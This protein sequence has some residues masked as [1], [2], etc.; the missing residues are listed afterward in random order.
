MCFVRAPRD[1]SHAECRPFDSRSSNFRERRRAAGAVRNSTEYPR[2]RPIFFTFSDTTSTPSF[3]RRVPSSA[4]HR[5]GVVPGKSFSA[6]RV[7]RPRQSCFRAVTPRPASAGARHSNVIYRGVAIISFLL[8]SSTRRASLSERAAFLM[9]IHAGSC[10]GDAHEKSCRLLNEQI[11]DR[12]SP[13]TSRLP[14]SY[15]RGRRRP[16]KDQTARNALVLKQIYRALRSSNG[17]S[18]RAPGRL[19]AAG[20]IMHAFVPAAASPAAGNKP[21]HRPRRRAAGL[22]YYFLS[23]RR[24]RL[25][26]CSR[27]ERN[28]KRWRGDADSFH[29]TFIIA[30]SPRSAAS[31]SLEAK[32]LKE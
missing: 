13:V 26:L 27:L 19:S 8:G 12:R 14:G 4:P 29:G 11:N 32:T 22:F 18:W 30:S 5:S 31:K 25:A 3:V 15:R 16:V 24:D 21:A 28:E 1:A 10:Y 9:K 6:L 23:E 7:R 2:A 20:G 17:L